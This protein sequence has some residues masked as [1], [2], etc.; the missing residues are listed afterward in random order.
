M[1]GAS[2]SGEL[3]ST[4][5]AMTLLSPEIELYN[6]TLELGVELAELE[7]TIYNLRSQ[8]EIRQIAEIQE[9][10]R[11]FV[12]SLKTFLDSPE[13]QALINQL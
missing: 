7:T 12:N 10:H 2:L 8:T 3:P 4:I 9:A 11:P 5:P 6:R 1:I 13:I